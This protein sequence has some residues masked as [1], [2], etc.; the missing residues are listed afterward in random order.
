M[1]ETV[2]KT[3]MCTHTHTVST[4]VLT[5]SNKP[6]QTTAF[7]MIQ[8]LQARDPER[9]LGSTELIHHNYK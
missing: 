7:N 1:F 4:V 9:H 3:R 6:T 2:T 8:T 5:E